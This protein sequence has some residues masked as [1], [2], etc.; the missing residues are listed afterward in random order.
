MKKK[1]IF[2]L[3]F[4]LFVIIIVYKN[5]FY[6]FYQQDEWWALG[7]IFIEPMWKYFS[8][9]SFFGLVPLKKPPS[10]PGDASSGPQ[11]NPDLE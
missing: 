11:S 5:L 1:S 9:F 10:S 3:V 4:F 8:H 7:G 2:S 6:T